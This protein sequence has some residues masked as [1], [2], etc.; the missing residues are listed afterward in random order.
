[1]IFFHRILI[2]F[3][4]KGNWKFPHSTQSCYFKWPL[5]KY[6]FDKGHDSKQRIII[7]YIYIYINTNEIPGE[8]LHK[9]HDIFTCENNM[10]SSHMKYHHCYGNNK[11]C[12]LQQKPIKVEWFGISLVFI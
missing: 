3:E 5:L 7:V 12:L 8:L 4:I 11:L 2:N 10:L 6:Y 9:K 1:M